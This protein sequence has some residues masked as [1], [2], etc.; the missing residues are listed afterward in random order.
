MVSF[1]LVDIRDVAV[2]KNN[3]PN[4]PKIRSQK[5]K[6]G[7]D[8]VDNATVRIRTRQNEAQLQLRPCWK[9]RTSNCWPLGVLWVFGNQ[10]ALFVVVVFERL[11]SLMIPA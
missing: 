8:P 3:D 11:A 5:R 10:K 2:M 7:T 4:V 9:K 6:K 1:E